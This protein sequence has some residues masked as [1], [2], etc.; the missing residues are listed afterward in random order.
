[1]RFPIILTIILTGVLTSVA[2]HKDKVESDCQQLS[3]G[4][5]SDNKEAVNEVITNLISQ[6]PGQAHTADNLA[7]LVNSIGQKCEITA[8]V[9]CY[10]CIKTLPKQSEIRVIITGSNST[11]VLDISE[12]SNG[13]MIF[14]SMHE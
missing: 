12:D 13:N 4:I 5:A 6:L 2:C 8:T 3:T 9:L 1:M 11:K 7:K 14:G 10:G